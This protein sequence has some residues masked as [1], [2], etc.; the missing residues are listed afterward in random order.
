M[1]RF[2]IA[3]LLFISIPLILLGGIYLWTDPFRTLHAF[4]INDIDGT[5]REYLST[6]LFLRNEPKYHYNSFIFASSRGGGM[7]TYQWKQ[8][9]PEGAQPFMFQAWGETLTGVE[10]K[11]SY[12][13]EQ[14]IPIDNALI[15]LDI[16][17]TFKDKQISTDAL[18]MKH[19]IFTSQSKFEYNVV[20]FWNFIQK[21]S[22]WNKSMQKRAR[23]IRVACETDT[24]TNDWE[25]KNRYNYTELPPQDSLKHC[26]E[27]T[28]RTFFEQVAHSKEIIPVSN[29]LINERFDKQLHQIRAILDAQHTD[30]HIIITPAPCYTNPAINQQDLERLRDIFGENRVHDYTGI[31]EM[32]EDYNNYSD[33]IHFGLRVGYMIVE[34]IYGNKEREDM[35]GVE[36]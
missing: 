23:G 2:V 6:E 29:P 3:I 9:L 27:M 18:D 31:N 13:N 26:S 11:M 10:L 16:P 35:D 21:P 25:T 4:D 28:R 15:L 36:S 14:H 30:Y 20:Q 22:F 19:Y 5:N 17:N 8:Y 1:R 7:N 12:L 33:P 34:E 32:T 24:I